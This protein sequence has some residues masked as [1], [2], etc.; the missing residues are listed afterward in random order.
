MCVCV[1]VLVRVCARA[2]G[3]VIVH[4]ACLRDVKNVQQNKY[5]GFLRAKMYTHLNINAVKKC[6]TK[7]V[8]NVRRPAA[9]SNLFGQSNRVMANVK[10]K[11]IPSY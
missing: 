10:I 8:S 9:P 4:G 7:S 11:E 5:L 3:F 2:E 6:M 1:C